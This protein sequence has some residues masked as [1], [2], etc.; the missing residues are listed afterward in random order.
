MIRSRDFK[1]RDDLIRP[2]EGGITFTKND[3][4]FKYHRGD[5]PLLI[6]GV[7][8][9]VRVHKIYVNGG[10]SSKVIFEHCFQHFP[11][12]TKAKLKHSSSP[13]ISF[14]RPSLWPLGTIIP[15]PS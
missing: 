9:E 11:A 7:V 2:S 3:P 4:I 1:G 12:S 13:L 8:D 6:Q 10:S 14:D 5:V 15:P